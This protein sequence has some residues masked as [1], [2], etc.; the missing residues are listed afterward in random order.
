[1]GHTVTH[2]LLNDKCHITNEGSTFHIQRSTMTTRKT[3]PTAAAAATTTTVTT[4]DT[5]TTTDGHNDSDDNRWTQVGDDKGGMRARDLRV[6]SHRQGMSFL[7][8]VL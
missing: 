4:V 2:T 6:L 8:D 7:Y 3:L 5:T 1:M